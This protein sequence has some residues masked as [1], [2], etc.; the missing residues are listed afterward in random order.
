MERMTG[1]MDLGFS[2]AKQA[3]HV[4]QPGTGLATHLAKL[5]GW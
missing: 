1:C 4:K 2:D 5:L 3:Q